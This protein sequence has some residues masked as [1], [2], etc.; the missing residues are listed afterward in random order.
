MAGAQKTDSIGLMSSP[1]A[2]RKQKTV[3]GIS[4]Y[5]H[6][7]AIAFLILQAPL[8]ENNAESPSLTNL[9]PV[10]SRLFVCPLIVLSLSGAPLSTQRIGKGSQDPSVLRLAD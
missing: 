3:D 7:L 4:Q 1:R 2:E 8:R 9:L 5:S 6:A 10:S